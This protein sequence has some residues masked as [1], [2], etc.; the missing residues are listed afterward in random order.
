MHKN[1]WGDPLPIGI[2][3]SFSVIS[4]FLTFCG[5]VAT[6]VYVHLLLDSFDFTVCPL[7]RRLACIPYIRLF[8]HHVLSANSSLKS[9]IKSTRLNVSR[10]PSESFKIYFIFKIV[11]N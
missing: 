5:Q 3:T 9:C 10:N 4:D 11:T 6:I 8:T 7:N 1:T 2:V